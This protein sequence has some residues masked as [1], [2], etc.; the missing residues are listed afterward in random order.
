MELKVNMLS[1][2]SQAQNNHHMISLICSLLSKEQV[3]QGKNLQ[4]SEASMNMPRGM[5]KAWSVGTRLLLDRSKTFWSS[6]A[7]QDKGRCYFIIL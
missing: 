3:H 4:S 2:L 5:G 6:T 7:Q 1:E